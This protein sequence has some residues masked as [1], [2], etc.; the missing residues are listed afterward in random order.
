MGVSKNIGKPPKSSILIW[1]S[2]IFTIRFQVALFF[3]KHLDPW[4]ILPAPF[5][6]VI[7]TTNIGVSSR[8]R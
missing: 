4:D 2:I 3:L 5:G 1:F 6:G 7:A 8:W